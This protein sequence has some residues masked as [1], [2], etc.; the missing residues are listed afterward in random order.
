MRKHE[1]RV[2]LEVCLLAIVFLVPLAIYKG[3]YNQVLIKLSL[4]Q[5]LL[6]LSFILCI[7]RYRLKLI[8][9][10]LSLPILLFL[11]LALLSL[12]ASK[13]KWA[14][15]D[16]V[17]RLITYLLICFVTVNTVRDKKILNRVVF[18]WLLS[19]GLACLYGLW[20]HFF[21]GMSPIRSTFGNANFFA[22]YLVLVFP[23]VVAMLV[24]ALPQKPKFI[25]LT[26]LLVMIVVSL[27]LASS[28]G[29]WFGVAAGLA[30]MAG[31]FFLPKKKL[32]IAF[33]VFLLIVLALAAPLIPRL[34]LGCGWKDLLE[35]EM[36]TGTLG[37]R[38]LIW[39]GT[40][41]MI[42]AHPFFGS[43][44]GSFRAAY[45]DYRVP[46]YFKN[47]H[48]VDST[49]HAHNEFLELG[50]EMGILG[51]GAFLWILVVCLRQAVA[52]VRV[53]EDKHRR[54]LV[55]GLISGVA[56]MLATNL[57][58]VNLH[59]PSSA[60]F[61]W[62]TLG[63]V[64]GQLP[65]RQ[66][67][68]TSCRLRIARHRLPAVLFGLSLVASIWIGWQIVAKPFLADVHFQRA[69]NY[70]KVGDWEKTISEYKRA[71]EFD[72]YFVKVHYRLGFAYVAKGEID[73][74]I[75][76]YQKVMSLAPN[77]ARIH[78]NLATLYLK[79]GEKEEAIKSLER[80]LRLNPYDAASHNDLGNLYAERRQWDKAISKYKRALALIPDDIDLLAN[81]GKVY[82][83]TGQLPEATSQF[84]RILEL[85]PGN[86]EAHRLLKEIE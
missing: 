38:L 42:A 82:L 21:G 14:A 33:T 73:K 12:I 7:G 13:Y 69:I 64:M 10:P 36:E 55:I 8:R 54:T 78:N 29:A 63:L 3:T 39:R 81:L 34:F 23:V 83:K 65:D 52:L 61:F 19:T 60:I 72:P 4:T 70:R 51:L 80:A 59:F 40:L 43:G 57:V 20:Q 5:V 9:T 84:K 53:A 71:V 50:G 18:A 11:S 17:Y 77:F 26:L 22:A 32:I 27:L 25:L 45:P 24:C 6:L 75:S 28:R 67:R 62:L 41:K 47:P 2:S 85:D 35:E 44:I 74:A 31:L 48:A 86:E 1:G 49:A 46:E 30:L 37:L 79:K 68:E 15:A 66:G 56:G 16:E 76:A 58:G